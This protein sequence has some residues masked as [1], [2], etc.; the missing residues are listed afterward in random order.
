MKT[1]PKRRVV[2][3]GDAALMP[4]E[5]SRAPGRHQTEPRNPNVSLQSRK[6]LLARTQEMAADIKARP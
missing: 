4:A 2:D 1:G 5:L 3:V 6:Q